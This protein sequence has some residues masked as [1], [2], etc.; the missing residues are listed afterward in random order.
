MLRELALFGALAPSILL[1]FLAAILLSVIL[2]RLVAA[3]GVY[4]FLWHPPLARFGLF[5]CVFSVL[6]LSTG[7]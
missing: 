4:R 7:P 6:V 3:L 5:L 1:Y 2:D